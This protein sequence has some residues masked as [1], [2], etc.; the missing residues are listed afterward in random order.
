MVKLKETYLDKTI[1]LFVCV[2]L[3]NLPHIRNLYSVFNSK[4][5]EEVL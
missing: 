5:K 1:E 2:Y 3:Y 4:H